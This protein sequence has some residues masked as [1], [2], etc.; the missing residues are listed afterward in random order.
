MRTLLSG[1][2]GG[3]IGA[4]RVG[5]LAGF[6]KI[7]SFDMGGTSTDVSL[8]DS[9]AGG[10]QTTKEAVIAGMPIG[11]PML[12]IHTVG[13]GG[14]SIARDDTGGLL[15]VGPESAG[16]YPVR[17]PMPKESYPR[18]PLTDANLL[19]G[20]LDAEQFLDGA[21]LLDEP[22][23]RELASKHCVECESLEE[24]AASIVLLAE[25]SMEKAIRVVSIER[26]YDPREFTLLSFGGA[27]PLHLYPYRGCWC[28]ACLARYRL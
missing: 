4:W 18:L 3:V 23:T 7:I 1:P 22:R 27:G 12:A 10:L 6:D 8:L 20:R 25:A 16:A 17:S 28:R 24:L 9:N 13:A 2:A 11:V 5:L 14:G 21:M 26:G 15:H 19:L